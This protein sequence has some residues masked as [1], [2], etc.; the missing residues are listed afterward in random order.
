[1]RDLSETLERLEREMRAVPTEEGDRLEVLLRERARLLKILSHGLAE[2]PESERIECYE[3]LLEHYA[4]GQRLGDR[5]RQE[6]ALL[7]EAWGDST[8]ERQ[9]LRMFDAVEQPGGLIEVG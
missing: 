3:R 6:R 2:L 7:V 1:M 8:R 5:L 4:A 9:L